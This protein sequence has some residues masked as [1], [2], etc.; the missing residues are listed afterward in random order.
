MTQRTQILAI[1]AEL[2]EFQGGVTSIYG[3]QQS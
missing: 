3:N 1:G 2:L